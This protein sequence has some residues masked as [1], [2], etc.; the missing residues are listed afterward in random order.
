MLTEEF[1]AHFVR[2]TKIR[3]NRFHPLVWINSNPIIGKNVYI[4]GM[5]EVNA[6]GASV[7]IGDN[8]DIASFVAINCADSHEKC[9]GLS[10]RIKSKDI[11]IGQN[12]FIGSHSVVKGGAQ[13]GHHS[14]IAAGTIVDGVKIPPYSL[15]AGNPMVVK[16][17]YYK[18]KR[19]S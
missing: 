5:S 10:K 13:V 9:I 11:V 17:G 19:R 18:G 16:K 7:E 1:A 3:K 8:C 15:I 6:K 2:L 12:V 14:V 4:G